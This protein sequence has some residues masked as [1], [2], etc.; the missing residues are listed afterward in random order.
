MRDPI[1][2]AR[3]AIHDMLDTIETVRSFSSG[4]V[5]DEFR[6]PTMSRLAVERAIEIILEAARKI[7]DD[8]TT[9][10]PEIPWQKFA[11]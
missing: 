1:R 2:I 6:Q 9:S 3:L 10:E 8:L 11:G 4:L 7:P 5:L